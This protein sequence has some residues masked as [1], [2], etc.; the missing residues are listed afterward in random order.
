MLQGNHGLNSNER[1]PSW[2]V[3]QDPQTQLF[4]CR[5]AC[6]FPKFTLSECTCFP[7]EGSSKAVQSGET[8]GVVV[9]IAARFLMTQPRSAWMGNSLFLSLECTPPCMGYTA[10]GFPDSTVE[11]PRVRKDGYEPCFLAS[12]LSILGTSSSPQLYPKI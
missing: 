4:W 10:P 11:D 3:S 12:F 1:V 6:G 2:G 5:G 7:G 9:S 8:L